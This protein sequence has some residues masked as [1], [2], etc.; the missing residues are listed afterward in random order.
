[1]KGIDIIVPCKISGEEYIPIFVSVK[2]Y[3]TMSPREANTFLEKSLEA[4]DAEGVTKGLLLLC[5]IGQDRDD[6][7]NSDYKNVLGKHETSDL[8]VLK[9]SLHNHIS[10][11]I[12]EM[13]KKI[14]PKMFCIHDDE[15]EIHKAVMSSKA[16]TTAQQADIFALHH[17]FLHDQSVKWLDAKEEEIKS[18]LPSNYRKGATDL[19]VETF[20]CVKEDSRSE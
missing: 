10:T 2:N 18:I 19:F 15:F 7:N 5:V 16:Q 9:D 20:R 4:L 14:V 6:I 8:G 12:G 1:M 11:S 17:E 13:K 3:S